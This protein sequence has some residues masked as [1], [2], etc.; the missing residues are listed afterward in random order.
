MVPTLLSRGNGLI[1]LKD[2]QRRFTELR[3][4]ANLELRKN[5]FTYHNAI[6]KAS[7]DMQGLLNS[8]IL[9]RVV[10]MT[11]LFSVTLVLEKNLV[12]FKN[13]LAAEKRALATVMD[14]NESAGKGRGMLID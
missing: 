8:V 4:Q 9:C 12:E 10:W 6:L 14:I 5:A 3:D 1:Q 2:G 7:K 13:T 11:V